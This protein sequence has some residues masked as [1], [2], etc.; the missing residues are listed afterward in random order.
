MEQGHCFH[1]AVDIV[2]AALRK[3]RPTN[4]SWLHPEPADAQSQELSP[5]LGATCGF[6]AAVV[7]DF[8]PPRRA[9]ARSASAG[10][11]WPAEQEG[12]HCLSQVFDV[13]EQQVATGRHDQQFTVGQPVD[14]GRRVSRFRQR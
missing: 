6:R 9:D 5:G 7:K 4:A 14:D 10:H 3:G 1:E 11:R 8:L 12:L 2:S 13:S